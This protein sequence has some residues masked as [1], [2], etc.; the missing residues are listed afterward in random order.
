MK[1]VFVEQPMDWP[2]SA[3]NNTDLNKAFFGH[4]GKI[5][6]SPNFYSIS[7]FHNFEPQIVTEVFLKIVTLHGFLINVKMVLTS[8]CLSIG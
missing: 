6:E 7:K 2:G 8:A 4:I 3:N 1:E 5:L